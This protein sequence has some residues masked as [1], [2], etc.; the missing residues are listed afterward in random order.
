MSKTKD[1]QALL[2]SLTA[3]LIPT[4]R[5]AETGSGASEGSIFNENLPANHT[6]ESSEEI[7]NYVAVFG[8]AGQKAAGEVTKA[9]M[10]ANAELA[11][12][13]IHIPMGAFGHGDYRINRV[14]EATIPPAEKG[15]QATKKPSFGSSVTA[16]TF[17][18]SKAKSGL[19]GS[20]RAAIKADF[21]AEFGDK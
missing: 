15:G 10:K 1:N 16:I 7:F 18:G 4:I 17:V 14:T 6:P 8:A 20:A 19:L 12:V 2:E 11:A 9:A 21:A 3:K 13:D 5:G